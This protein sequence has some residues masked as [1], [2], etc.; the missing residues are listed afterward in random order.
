VSDDTVWPDRSEENTET[1]GGE[2]F[3][4]LGHVSGAHGLQ[5]WVKVYSDTSPRENIVSYSPWYLRRDGGQEQA[6]KVKSGRLQGK[7]VVAKLEGCNDRDCAESL[8]GMQI[9]V[10]RSA[11]PP[12]TE[13]EY[14]WADL[15]GLRVHTVDGLDLGRVERLFETGAN[16]VIVVVGDRE[17]LIPYVWQQVVRDVDLV[18]GVM[19]VDWDAD[20]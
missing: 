5:G 14:Y 4:T 15:V 8:I 20:F 16:D 11:L 19:T 10:P 9:L 18:A 3:V 2:R 13:G 6:W 7:L 12:T 17:R 1:E